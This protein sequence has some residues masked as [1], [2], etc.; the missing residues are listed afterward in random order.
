VNKIN[1]NVRA[2]SVVV[3]A[4]EGKVEVGTESGLKEVFDAVV[5]TMPVPQLL[6]LKNMDAILNST[7]I[8][9]VI[10]VIVQI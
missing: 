10:R 6:Q 7:W 2:D 4:D 1:F 3:K 8:F 5:S 9:M